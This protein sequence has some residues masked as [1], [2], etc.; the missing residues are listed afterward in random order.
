VAGA[1]LASLG[2]VVLGA[3]GA[4]AQTSSGLEEVYAAWVARH[5]GRGGDRNV[6]LRLG[7]SKAHS[8][9]HSSASGLATLD[10]IAGSLR[11]EVDGL[12]PEGGDVWLIDNLSGA[13][14][15]AAPES[16]DAQIPVGPLEVRAGRAVLVEEHLDLPS[17]FEVDLVAVSLPG[18]TP[19]E[20]GLLFGAP[21]LWQ[22]RYT[23]TQRAAAR[24]GRGRPAALAELVRQGEIL[25][26][27][28]T[29]GGNGRTC[30]TCHPAEN[31]FT[32]DA[33]FIA[34]LP[35]DD[36]LFV[37]EF[38]PELAEDFEK[39]ALMRGLGLILENTN[40]FEPP[41]SQFTMR[42]VPHTLALPTSL[43]PPEDFP[44]EDATG[45]SGDG[46]PN[47]GSLRQFANGAIRQHFP[48]TTSRVAGADFRF[49]TEAELDALAAF[50]LSLGRDR[51]PDVTP[52]SP[53]ELPLR[54]PLA[55]TGKVLFNDTDT[56]DGSAGKCARCHA[57]AGASA[58]ASGTNGNFDTG[59]ES[60]PSHPADAIVAEAGD[61]DL[62]DDPPDD[63]LGSP[64]DGTFNTPSLVEAADTAPFFHD[65]AA[66]TLEEAVDFYNSESFADSP[67][68]NFLASASS[69][70][71]NGIAI[72]LEPEEVVAVAAFLRVLNAL[73]NVRS[74]REAARSAPRSDAGRG[75]LEVAAAD[76]ADAVEVLAAGDLHADAQQELRLAEELLLRATQG[77]GR[78][79]TGARRHLDAAERL[80]VARGPRG[81]SAR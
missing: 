53:T 77:E 42:G 10:R 5:E 78:L 67:A 80:M 52:G 46:A 27:E 24:G 70:E 32:I 36:P 58:L 45:W 3:G 22:R 79:L 47:G 9:R 44:A 28:E 8:V 2:A 39:P 68:G 41:E 72:H 73:E 23:E 15:S 64:G 59:V 18:A 61:P 7:W 76:V 81:R 6:A 65:N 34:T 20:G 40:G 69:G 74:A 63:G 54:S 12:G 11:V 30:G 49:A 29:F 17:A 21:G 71:A 75:A 37:A 14:R 4:S 66:L 50:Q 57:N 33:A 13:G 55:E 35:D 1:V 25:F 62:A 51:D 56:S 31:N 48:R 38:V 26:F 43:T 19:V 16:G 60:L